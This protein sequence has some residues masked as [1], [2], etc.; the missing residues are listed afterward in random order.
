MAAPVRPREAGVE[1]RKVLVTD[2]TWANTDVEAA[3]LAEVGAELVHAQAGEEDELIDLV[4]D[5]EGIL[6]CFKQVTP[7]V[8][9]AG[10]QLRVI[11]R[12]GIGTDNIAV[13][14]ATERGIVVAN[15][16]EY[17]A[18]EVAE[19]ALALMFSLVRGVPRY[20]R[21][22]RAGD[23]SL[24]TGLPTRRIAGTTLGIVGHG[25]IGRALEARA[26]GLGMEV[27]VHTRTTGIPLLDLAAAADVVSL[28]VPATRETECLVDRAFLAAMKPSS[29]LINCSRG[30]LVDH[31]ALLAALRAGEIA[32]AGLDVFTPEPLAPEHPLLALETVVATPHT[33][34]YSEQS[35]QALARQAAG[36][37]AD[38]LDGR[39]PA[40]VV[41]PEVLEAGAER[42]RSAGLR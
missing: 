40:H 5:C 35:V 32:G 7:A 3:V 42:G 2:Y 1:A 41:N 14:V 34:F 36:N 19:H 37:V 29:Y 10:E 33:A 38:V 4:H 26:R 8:V 24:A 23:W 12:Y 27:L 15:V 39:R 21:A 9:R 31:E 6:T 25:P 16:P 20:D 11:G 30:A 22:V 13:D 18:D 28:H 17:C